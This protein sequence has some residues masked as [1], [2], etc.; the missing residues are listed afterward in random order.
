MAPSKKK[1]S[2]KKITAKWKE[3]PPRKK[4]GRKMRSLNRNQKALGCFSKQLKQVEAQE[5]NDPPF[6]HEKRFLSPSLSSSEAEYNYGGKFVSQFQESHH[7]VTLIPTY[8]EIRGE[9]GKIITFEIEGRDADSAAP[10]SFTLHAGALLEEK[11]LGKECDL[12][13]TLQS[14]ITLGGITSTNYVHTRTTAQR[15][16][17]VSHPGMRRRW[18]APSATERKIA[19]CSVKPMKEGQYQRCLHAIQRVANKGLLVAARWMHDEVVECTRVVQA[20]HEH[21][22]T[23][24]FAH[25]AAAVGVKCGAAVHVDKRDTKTALWMCL[26][27]I[28]MFWP[29]AGCI[30]RLRDGDVLSFDAA[31]MYHC[32][33]GAPDEELDDLAPYACISLYTN[34]SQLREFERQ[35]S[36]N[37]PHPVLESQLPYDV[38]VYELRLKNYKLLLE[39]ETAKLQSGL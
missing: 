13:S 29:E 16:D 24:S 8:P 26:G 2:N 10:W 1:E 14:C 25:L 9:K 39:L 37:N 17:W 7:N 22:G 27:D 34:G 4:G 19:P 21:G 23:P 38:Y 11:C 15:G 32:M 18:K 31:R 28:N 35:K 30:L 33:M 5:L 36:L 12:T 20:C 3:T 6:E